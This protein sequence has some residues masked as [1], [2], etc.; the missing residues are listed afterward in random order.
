MADGVLREQIGVR[1]KGFLGSLYLERP[2]LE[3]KTDKFTDGQFIGD[4]ERV[5]LNNNAGDDTHLAACL[6]Y[7][8]YAL[9]DYPAPRCNLASVW[10]NGEPYGTY[11]HIEALKVRFLE[12]AFGDASGSLYEGVGIDFV[13]DWVTRFESKT[14][15]TDESFAPLLAVAQALRVSDEDLV[16]ELEQVVSLDLFVTFWALEVLVNH[17][18]AY[19]SARNN[20]FVYFDP[21]D[22]GRAVLL[23]WG[24][25]K[26]PTYDDLPLENHLFAELPRRLSRDPGWPRAWRAS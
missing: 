20:Y 22:G 4:T 5:T 23:P 1:R 8:I 13:E 15:D 9:A 24:V 17:T 25:D 16:Q 14:D 6:T 7:E 12:R 18:D 26:L 2:A 11:T 21:S 10:V 3:L 19:G